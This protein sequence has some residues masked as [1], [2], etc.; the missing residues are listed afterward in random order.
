[1]KVKIEHK[2]RWLAA[3]AGVLII[4]AGVWGLQ[5]YLNYLNIAEIGEKYLYTYYR[6][7]QTEVI[8]RI[9]MFIIAEAGVM[10]TT[11]VIR[12]N[13]LKWDNTAVF[14][15]TKPLFII[16]SSLLAL[17][18]SSLLPYKMAETALAAFN[19]TWFLHSDPIFGRNIGYYIFQRPFYRDITEWAY[20]FTGL[21]FAYQVIIY[22]MYYVRAGGGG[23]RQI[24]KQDG[25]VKH[26]F[27]GF[28]MIMV[29]FM[30]SSGFL[31]EE[32]MFGEYDGVVGGKYT[33]MMIWANFYR[34]TPLLLAAAAIAASAMVWKRKYKSVLFVIAVY[35]AL[36][37][38][39]AV[40]AVGVQNFAVKPNETSMERPYIKNNIGCTNRAYGLEDI[41]DMQ[42]HAYGRITEEG[43]KESVQELES[44]AVIDEATALSAFNQLQTHRNNYVFKDA[45]YMTY[46]ENG[47][48]KGA[49]VAVREIKSDEDE[50]YISRKMRFTHG[51][52]VV[53]GSVAK[54]GADGQPEL[55]VKDMNTD[56]AAPVKISQP[57][58]YFG[59]TEEEY[60]IVNSLQKEFDYYDGTEEA[61][62]S[63][64]GDAGVELNFIHRLLYA[65]KYAD[66]NLAASTY[67]TSESKILTNVN[68]IE[69][70]EYAYPYLTFDE[71]PYI[72][73]SR[74]GRIIWILDGYTTTNYYP[75]AQRI[76]DFDED[77]GTNYVRNSVKVTVDA[78]S[79]EMNGY[80]TDYNDPIIQTYSKIYPESFTAG[81]MPYEIAAQI[82]YPE[83][84]F[85]IQAE[86][87]KQY[88]STNPSTFYSKSDVWEFAKEKTGSG[89]EVRSMSPYIVRSDMFGG[90]K[91]NVMMIPY[92]VANKDSSLSAWLAVSSGP[93]HYG[94]MMVCTF[95]RGSQIN[96]TLQVENKIDSDSMI[97]AE[98]EKL[99]TDKA[100][101][102]RGEMTVLP[103]MRTV[104]YIEPVYTLAA[105]QGALPELKKIIA[106]CG[107]T[108]VVENTLAEA[109]KK[110]AQLLPKQE[111]VQEIPEVLS[112]AENDLPQELSSLLAAGISKYREA[113]QF[114]REGDWVNYGKT[115]KDFE[116]IL[117]LMEYKMAYSDEEIPEAEE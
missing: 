54:T 92:T 82:K 55:I 70:A 27:A 10:I 78:Y 105:A 23:L 106:V 79:G 26:L 15:N 61:E 102:I 13:L 88:H 56:A 72:T 75:Y 48:E 69:R 35:P 96:G 115:M 91:E 12:K 101:V 86:L 8:L 46:N 19:P 47:Q 63:Y 117:N 64:D 16:C 95:P 31:A 39:V 14:L 22:F 107:D 110:L 97:T 76:Y 90:R 52:G 42:Y 32:F 77:F 29:V 94:A 65:A 87:F 59:E 98:I 111:N 38:I 43:I 93:D 28:L 108:A 37:I 89:P 53:A 57:R 21:L 112:S 99:K 24:A 80:I 73:I 9:I 45:D 33:R 103:V 25:I 71:D 116:E 50:S 84:L 100:R 40:A 36:W 58:I 51:Y 7:I 17:F 113:Q 49:Y 74:D 67:C 20:I 3:L 2:G 18:I 109:V 6:V 44:V 83:K 81:A 41:S 104:I 1:M 34:I 66:F 114:G 60:V 68:I 85:K 62:F 30:V 4:L 11:A 5:L